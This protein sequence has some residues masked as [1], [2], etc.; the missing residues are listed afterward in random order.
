MN[1]FSSNKYSKVGVMRDIL[2]RDYF[3]LFKFLYV[4]CISMKINFDV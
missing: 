1:S 2:I 4:C 3:F